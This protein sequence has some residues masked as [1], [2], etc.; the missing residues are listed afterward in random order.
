M[1]GKMKAVT[2]SM[3]F[4]VVA[5]LSMATPAV[6]QPGADLPAAIWQDPVADA[7]HPARMEVLHI[8]SGGETINGIVYI[9]AGVG[10]HPTVVV[11]HGLPGNEKNLDLAQ[12]LRRA[13]WNAVTFN[14]RGSWGSPGTYRFG[15][16]PQDLHAVLA[17]LRQSDHAAA[18]GIDPARMAVVGHSMGGW[19]TAMDGGHEPG[20][21]ALAV[22]SA[23]NMGALGRASHV[24]TVKLVAE[25]YETLAGTTP[26]ALAG[27]LNAHS[28]DYD[29][30]GQAPALARVPF[31]VLTS[32]DGFGPHGDQLVAAIR[33]AGGT[34][35]ETAHVDTDHGWSDRRIDLEARIIRF[36]ARFLN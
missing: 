14:Y 30:L 17:Y 22:Y 13:G 4:P 19:V 29:F 9:A 33:K 15:Q 36:L 32:N 16:N 34:K 1:V 25:N 21:V 24:E 3:L 35:I 5:A 27:E 20:V 12:A 23:A 31:L 7:A 28:T 10:P 8:P 11:C 18:L 6:A 2:M 26:D